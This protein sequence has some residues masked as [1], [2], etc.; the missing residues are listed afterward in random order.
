MALNVGDLVAYLRADDTKL[1][2]G[3]ASAKSKLDSFGE[4]AKAGL[5][6]AGAVAGVA[7]GGAIAS[8]VAANLDIGEGRAKLAAQLNLS[9][10]DSARLGEVAGKVYANNWGD[11]LDQINDAMRSV[12]QN[13]GDVSTMSSGELQK[14]TESALAL[15]STFDVDLATATEAAGK[16]I[17]NGLAKD[18][19][20]A[21]DI[22][23]AGFQNGVDR[24]GDFLD[25]LNEYSPQF[26]KLGIDGEQATAI[27]SAGLKA[28]ARDTDTIADAF[29]EFSLR[30]I[31][32]SKSTADAFHAIGMSADYFGQEIAAGG[33]RANR[34]TQQS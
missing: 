5:K 12:G 33:D 22:M 11:N 19:T 4:S 2:S 10:E 14:V 25:T 3:L 32:G 8:G 20:E 31:D 34:A 30:S 29:K 24:S 21:F 18:S 23:T 13:I 26:K 1:A 7:V 17:K 15:S 6:A 9:K 27:L 16:L 28:G